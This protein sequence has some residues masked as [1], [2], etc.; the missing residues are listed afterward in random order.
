MGKIEFDYATDTGFI[1]EIKRYHLEK[2]S[3]IRSYLG[4]SEIGDSCLR[5]LWFK[6]HRRRVESSP[7]NPWLPR[8]FEHG[9]FTEEKIINELKAMG[10]AITDQ[11]KELT[12]LD[13]Q[14]KGHIDG[15]IKYKGRLRLLEIKS[16]NDAGFK[17]L[18]TKTVMSDRRYYAQLQ[19]Y[20]GRLGLGTAIFIVENKNNQEL[21][22]ERVHYV[23]ER[24]NEF[25][26]IAES[27]LAAQAPGPRLE[28]K[29]ECYFCGFACHCKE[30]NE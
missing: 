4:M 27:I 16:A 11:Q 25:L 10:H 12:A 14:V 29:T 26:E 1:E 15:I 6:A 24:E 8:I 9:H 17:K 2:P 28:K 7:D 20:M 21:Y 19:L 5:R 23:R 13:G 22:V 3:E 30:E 18:K